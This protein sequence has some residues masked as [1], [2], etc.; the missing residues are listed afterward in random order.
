MFGF[1]WFGRTVGRHMYVGRAPLIGF[2][3]FTSS[4]AV[5][6][7]SFWKNVKNNSK[8]N[9]TYVGTYSGKI[10]TKNNLFRNLSKM[11]KSSRFILIPILGQKYYKMA[12]FWPW[13][14]WHSGHH[15]RLQNGRSRVQI[16][17]RYLYIAL[18]SS[19]FNMHRH[20]VYLRK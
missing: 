2:D 3:C 18:M 17:P 13:Q 4:G 6:H 20:C 15:V 19:Q 16:P 11:S 5:W 8:L 10:I 7:E 14:A 1:K 9:I 12:T